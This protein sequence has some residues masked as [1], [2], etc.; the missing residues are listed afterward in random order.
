MRNKNLIEALAQSG[1]A[2]ELLAKNLKRADFYSYGE[3]SLDIGHLR[4]DTKQLQA[5]LEALIAAQ[6]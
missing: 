3:E 1:Q 5:K 2:A 4:R 6:R